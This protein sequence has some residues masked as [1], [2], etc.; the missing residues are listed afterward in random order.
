MKQPL[1]LTFHDVDRSAW[2]EDYIRRRAERLERLADDIIWCRVAVEQPSR[3]RNTGNLYR[4]SI[5]LSLPPNKDLV[6]A[7]ERPIDD[8]HMQLR[9]LIKS[10]FEALERQLKKTVERRRYDVKSHEEPPHGLVARVFPRE[11]Y[12]FIRSSDGREIYFN[13]RAVLHDG[14]ERL[15]IGT[16]VRFV[17]ESGEEGPQASSVQIVSKRGQRESVEGGS[18]APGAGGG[19]DTS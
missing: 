1:E 18:A 8:P 9:P 3:S 19:G 5:E 2:V 11:G 14:F 10:A 6:A 13:R 16:E 17:D 12:G 15:A 7:K 4:V